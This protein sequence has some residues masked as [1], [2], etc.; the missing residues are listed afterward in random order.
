MS[1]DHQQ[2]PTK[3]SPIA[4]IPLPSED[5]VSLLEMQLC[6]IV[7]E[8]KATIGLPRRKTVSNCLRAAR[9]HDASATPNDVAAFIAWKLHS[10]STHFR[11][12]GAVYIAIVEDYGGWTVWHDNKQNLSAEDVSRDDHDE[13]HDLL[14]YL[15]QLQ[16]QVVPGWPPP[17]EGTARNILRAVHQKYPDA[18]PYQ[19]SF[20]VRDKIMQCRPNTWGGV[21]VA[22]RQNW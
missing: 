11:S 1:E 4:G 2:R 5:D 6:Q 21:V 19:I 15:T 14:R 3:V 18:T 9:L 16:L 7:M 8:E 13:V 12:W 10:S 17:N 22:V 20:Y